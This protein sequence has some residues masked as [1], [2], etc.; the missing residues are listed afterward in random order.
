MEKL[1]LVSYAKE[2]EVNDNGDTIILQVED[3]AIPRKIKKLV[4]TLEAK[5]KELEGLDD[6]ADIDIIE[7]K[8]YE[9]NL[10][11]KAAIDDIF[12]EGTC[13]KVFGDIVPPVE[14]H[15]EFIKQIIPYFEEYAKERV[16]RL[17]K[18]NPDRVGSS[19]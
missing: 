14:R 1:R 13:K 4:K 16:Q 11:A 17:E 6:E 3:Q 12:G 2:I 8:N 19:I 15:I 5:A 18:Y 9:M 7:D 10:L